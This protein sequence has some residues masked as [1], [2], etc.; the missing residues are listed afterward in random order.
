MATVANLLVG[1]N[2]ASGIRGRLQDIDDTSYSNNLLMN[3]L[4]DAQQDF[5]LTGCCQHRKEV[6]PD[7]SNSYI[8]LTTTTLTYQHLAVYAVTHNNLP[9]DF[10]PQHEARYWAS[11]SSGTPTAWTIWMVSGADRMYFDAIPDTSPNVIVWFTFVPALLTSTSDNLLIPD[12][13][14]NALKAYV[15]WKVRA[16]D[17]EDGLADRAWAEYQ[18]ARETAAM[19]NEAYLTTGGHSR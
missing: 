8:N 10:A 14:H 7:G 12:K 16:T 3:F 15:E 1:P 6:T 4:S 5:A 17:R 9:L 19:L 2:S 11:P 18:S 13:W